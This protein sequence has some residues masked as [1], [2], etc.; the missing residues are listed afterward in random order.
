MTEI[1][2][3][4]YAEQ[5]IA[6]REDFLE[7]YEAFVV[8]ERPWMKSWTKRKQKEM[9]NKF[10]NIWIECSQQYPSRP[11]LWSFF[12]SGGMDILPDKDWDDGSST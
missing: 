9:E 8:E 6:L 7:F 4:H 5:M 3:I 1:Q 10:W 12:K 11:P 2:K